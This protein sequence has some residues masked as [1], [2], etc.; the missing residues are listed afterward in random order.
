MN[1]TISHILTQISALEDELLSE[2][3]AQESRLLYKIEGTRVEFEHS[4]QEA[5]QRMKVG[6]VRWLLAARPQNFLTAP[7]IYGIALPLALFDLCV[8]FYQATCFP[9]Y[10]IP[11]VK[12]SGYFIYDHQQLAYLNIIEKVDCLY[13][14][15]ANG[16]MA[17]AREINAPNNT[18]AP[19]STHADCAARTAATHDSWIMARRMSSKPSW[20]SSAQR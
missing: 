14:S 16:L 19:S 15:Y 17:Y 8:S 5:H 7:I 2:L 10:G 6:V 20:R 11:K 9:I 12:R 1:E 13:C 3:H 4:V 18:S